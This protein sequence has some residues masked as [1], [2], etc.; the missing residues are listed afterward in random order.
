MAV[1]CEYEFAKL[2]RKKRTKSYNISKV[3]GVLLFLETPS[4]ILIG[5]S[6][7]DIYCYCNH[8]TLKKLL[9]TWGHIGN[10]WH[11]WF[12]LVHHMYN[13]F[14]HILVPHAEWT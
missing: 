3:L 4:T 9:F 10:L 11:K 8:H 6:L 7:S 1:V 13:M 5:V 2:L 12:I 14:R